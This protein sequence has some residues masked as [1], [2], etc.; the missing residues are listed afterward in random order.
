MTKTGG[1]KKISK[2]WVFLI[3]GILIFLYTIWWFI[4]V[5]VPYGKKRDSLQTQITALEREI[6]QKDVKWRNYKKAEERLGASMNSIQAIRS[7]LPHL[8]DLEKIVMHLK[9]SGLDHDLVVEE[10]VPASYLSPSPYPSETLIHP[11]NLTFRLKG[12]FGAIG[13][14]IQFLDEQN[15]HFCHIRSINMERSTSQSYTVLALIKMEMFFSET[16]REKP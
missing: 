5:Y 14:F 13:K 7:K 11:V 2:L 12:D 1:H 4:F 3:S 8:K 16:G 10:E 15:Q 9:V 6:E